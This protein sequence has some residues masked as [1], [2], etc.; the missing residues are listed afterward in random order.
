MR[1]V[2]ITEALLITEAELVAETPGERLLLEDLATFQV[3]MGN[4]HLGQDGVLQLS[5]RRE[6]PPSRR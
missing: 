4:A 2:F 3:E 6:M 5:V 1:V